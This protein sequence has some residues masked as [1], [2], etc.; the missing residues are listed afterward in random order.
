M[1]KTKNILFIMADQLRWDYL[2]CYGHPYLKTPNIDKLAK[3][4][5]LFESAFVQSPI[6]GPSRASFYTGR[7]VFSHGATLNQVPLPIGELTI[8]DYLRK[9]NIKTAVVG[10]THMKPDK[11]G[12]ERLGLTK[13]TDIGMIVSEPGFD[14]YERD[15]GLHP[16]NWVKNYSTA[17][18]YNKW[19]NSLGYEGDNPWETWANSAEGPNG[20]LL[21]GWKLRNSNKQARIQEEHSETAYMTNRAIDFM[22][23]NKDDQWMLH[24]SFIKPHWPYIAPS[25]YHNMYSPN[26]FY[27]VVRDE[28]EKNIQ[29]EVYRAF[30]NARVSKVFSK[31]EVREAVITGYMGLIKQID[32]NLGRLFE[33]MEQNKLFQNT[34]IVFT[35][36]HGDYL[37]DHWLGEKELFH[38]QS[39]RVPLIIYDPSDNADSTR[40]QREKKL[41]ESIDLLPTFLEALNSSTSTHR[42]EGRSLLPIIR[43]NQL[44]DWRKSVFS[45]I[46]Y[47]LH[48][49]RDE[50]ELGPHEARAFM[51]RTE[52]WKYIYYK[53]FSPQ[54]FNLERDPNE[55]EDLGQNQNYEKIRTELKDLLL[56]RLIN[57]KN[58]LT[59]DEKFVLK[60]QDVE[61]EGGVMIG[62]W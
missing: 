21:S 18:T 33:F 36:D 59:V 61:S 11:D 50:L 47:G 44:N 27:E 8:G 28:K 24:L 38:E 31:M 42:L 29:H 5:L 13:E 32:D 9:D 60:G 26:Q 25:P 15:D 39:V 10:K 23:E 1:A 20:D 52:K 4:G 7:T 46:D 51:I 16:N 62:V 12:M 6:C 34:M 53:G 22:N 19:L 57:R 49:A 2:S 37:G 41:V 45:E 35:S 48:S 43:G 55:F 30:T 40:G 14:P 56:K 58:L 17:L 54:L 3:E